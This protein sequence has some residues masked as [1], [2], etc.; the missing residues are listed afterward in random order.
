MPITRQKQKQIAQEKNSQHEINVQSAL[1]QVKSKKMSFRVAAKEYSVGVG[2]LQSRLRGS[3][4]RYQVNRDKSW[5]TEADEL[6][7][8]EYI[9]M[10]ELRHDALAVE[11]VASKAEQIINF[12]REYAHFADIRLGSNWAR[13]FI[14]RRPKLKAWWSSGT[15]IQKALALDPEKL[16]A[17]FENVR[18]RELM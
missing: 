5:L 3:R 4:P 7:L 18:Y 8:E 11:E 17:Y 9:L 15:T 10:R 1:L 6:A 16:R 2:I 13:R 12:K 14:A